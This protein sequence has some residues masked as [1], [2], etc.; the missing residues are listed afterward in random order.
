MDIQEVDTKA[1]TIIEEANLVSV[2]N[3]ESYTLASNIWESL[4]GIMKKVGKHHDTLISLAHQ[5]H[6]EALSKKADIYDPLKKARKHVKY[7][8]EQYDFEQ[9]EIRK[10]EEA[11]L[12]EIA[13]KEEEERQ[14][15]EALEAEQN[16]EKEEAEAILEAPVYTPPVVVQ[17]TTPKLRGGPVYRTIWKFEV[18]DRMALI[19]AVANG[20][21]PARA[22]KADN[23]FLGEQARSLKN[24]MNFP[25]VRAY[26]E[27]C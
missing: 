11:R 4:G 2:T 12:R 18:V 7:I 27:R 8:M 19:R 13:R 20:Q 24:T 1:L 14:L 3:T 22:L 5:T 10:K 16:G 26:S 17:K 6:K 25:G 23:V 15:A 21:A 9:E